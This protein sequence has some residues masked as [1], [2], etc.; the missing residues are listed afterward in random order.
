MQDSYLHKGKRATMVRLLREKGITD[1]RVLSAMER[2][3][4]HLFIDD[5]F[6]NLAYEDNAIPIGAGQT[7]SQPSTVAYQSQLLDVSHSMKVLE[8]GTGS[9]YQTAV[10]C[11]MKAQVF[12]IERQ[13]VLFDRT[14]HMLTQMH[15]HPRC[16]LGNGYQ[17]LTEANFGLFDRVL[18]TCGAPCIPNDLLKQMKIGG[19]MVIPVGES[20]KQT[21]LRITK[22][23]EGGYETERFGDFKFVPMLQD[24][25]FH[26]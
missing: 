15:Y 12:T 11:E 25:N 19:I 16:F 21:M 26:S 17:G 24:I 10:L 4:R 8:I 1:E 13:K 5:A 20:K 22:T 6:E 7:I 23:R 2:V 9:G 14:R 3:P 18:I